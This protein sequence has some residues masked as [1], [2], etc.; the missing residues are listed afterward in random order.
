MIRRDEKQTRAASGGAERWPPA[1]G[2]GFSALLSEHVA[3]SLPV[4]RR[5]I[6][7]ISSQKTL[8][9]SQPSSSVAGKRGEQRQACAVGWARRGSAPRGAPAEGTLS[10]GG[11]GPWRPVT[12]PPPGARPRSAPFTNLSSLSNTNEVIPL[13]RSNADDNYSLASA[14]LCPGLLTQMLH[15]H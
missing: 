7:M 14:S 13:R 6:T 11:K 10:R 3:W 8:C 12:V 1:P 4:G 5:E 15:A 2:A 9:G